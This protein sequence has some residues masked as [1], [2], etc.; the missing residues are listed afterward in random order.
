MVK[1]AGFLSVIGLFALSLPAQPCS[2]SNYSAAGY[3][4]H[5]TGKKPLPLGDTLVPYDVMHIVTAVVKSLG[6][7]DG[8]AVADLYTP[9]AVIADDEAPYSWNG[10]TAGIQWVSAVEKACKNIGLTKLK[11]T[12]QPVNVFQQSAGNVYLAV[13][14]VFTGN[15]PGKQTFSVEGVFSFVL[16]LANGKWLIKSQTWTA[17]KAIQQ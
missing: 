12:I 11:S 5:Y 16:R 10:P 8:Q 14:V 13:P 3:K 7:F 9:N 2:A 4:I 17:K 6:S 15:L 1:T